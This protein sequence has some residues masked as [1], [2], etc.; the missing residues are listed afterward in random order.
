MIKKVSIVKCEDYNQ[1]NINNAIIK[2]LRDI[3]FKIKPNSKILI[4]PNLVSTNTPDQHSI[5]NYTLIDAL[6]KLFLEKKC[7]ITI[8]ESSA[9]YQKGYTKKA[10]KTSKIDKV[11][12]QYGAKLIEFENESIEEVNNLKFLDELFLPNLDKFDLI[13]NVPKIKTHLLMRFTG[14]VK[15]LYGL[16]PGGYKQFLHYKSKNINEMAEIFLD[17]YQSIKPKTLNIMDAV[18]GLDGGPA[19]VMGKPKKVGYILASEDPSA[20]DIIA[21]QMIGYSPSDIPTITMA[22]KRGLIKIKDIKQIGDFHQVI[23]EKLQKG[24]IKDIEKQSVLISETHTWPT[25]NKRK[26][27]DCKICINY[28]PVKAI[29]E[30]NGKAFI[31]KEKCIYCYTC[32]PKCPVQAIYHKSTLKNKL[33]RLIRFIFRI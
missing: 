20:L 24:E 25:V 10:Y 23:F 27:T 22:I 15:N 33:I 4:K 17:I 16:V 2:S 28:C 26:C 13:V 19:A 21:C 3:N 31:D 14:A 11:A 9:F 7:D 18:I 1:E 30:N 5:T 32:I 8:G 29:S 6:C 12:E